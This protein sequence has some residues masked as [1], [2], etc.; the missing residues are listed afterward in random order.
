MMTSVE[1]SHSERTLVN[2]PEQN[3]KMLFISAILKKNFKGKNVYTHIYQI[4]QFTKKRNLEWHK[5]SVYNSNDDKE[6]SLFRV[7]K[8]LYKNNVH[9]FKFFFEFF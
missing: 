5:M 2:E 7:F 9:Y 6:I 4:G 8:F 3:E 1:V